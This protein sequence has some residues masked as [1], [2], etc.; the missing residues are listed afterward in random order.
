MPSK[1]ETIRGFPGD[2][3]LD[4]FALHPEADRI[5]EALLPS[6]S[7]NSKYQIS[8]CSTP[9]GQSNMFYRIFTDINGFP[10]FKRSQIDCYSAIKMGCKLNIEV[11][12]RNFDED[13]FRQEFECQFIDEATSYFPYDLI[14]KCIAREEKNTDGTNFIGIDIG[15]KK[16]LTC[17]YIATLSQGK[18]YFKFME[19]WQN[20]SYASQLR[21]ISDTIKKNEISAGMI[22][23]TGLGNNLAEDLS[24]EFPFIEPVWFTA[25][26]KQ[27]MVL[28]VKTMMEQQRIEL[29]DERDLI[30]DIHAIKKSITPSNNIVFEANRNETGHADRFWA[31][32]LAVAAGNED[33]YNEQC[34]III[35]TKRVREA[36]QIIKGY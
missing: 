9:L 29:P 17:V 20:M 22:D 13:S 32:A 16:D 3:R 14:Q 5:F 30:S 6:I 24:N 15:R 2:V 1:P 27:E 23:A 36:D 11:I 33:I 26:I 8:I 4:E 28:R 18:F 21:L 25:Q 7:S 12:K 31:L 10:D 35:L 34:P 19:T